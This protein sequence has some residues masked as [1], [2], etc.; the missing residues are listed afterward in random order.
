MRWRSAPGV[1]R[2]VGETE[3][4]RMSEV[5]P[6]VRKMAAGPSSLLLLTALRRSVTEFADDAVFSQLD[7]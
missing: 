4:L 5:Q 6:V 3:S 2:N 7:V 1:K